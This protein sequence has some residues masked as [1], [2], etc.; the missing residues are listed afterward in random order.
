MV[1]WIIGSDGLSGNKRFCCFNYDSA[2]V[3]IQPDNSDFNVTT[4]IGVWSKATLN[5]NTTGYDGNAHK[6]T[7]S[8]LG[9]INQSGTVN[10][11][12][13]GTV[14]LANEIQGNNAVYVRDTATLSVKRGKDAGNNGALT[15]ASGATLEIAESA[16]SA[17]AASV[18]RRGNLTLNDGAKLKFNFTDRS[19]APVLAKSS[20]KTVTASGKVYVVVSATGVDK[21]RS[22]EHILTTC[23]GFSVATVELASGAPKWATG[24]SVNGDGNIVL[25]VKASGMILLVR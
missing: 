1:S 11:K 9:S 18:T 19:I 17:G 8:G 20:D 4:K 22:G 10:I 5:L 23:G 21:P 12:G 6:I 3:N 14:E 7:F 25:D 15:V 16:A 24:V 13:N 2:V